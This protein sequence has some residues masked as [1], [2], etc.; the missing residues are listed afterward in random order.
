MKTNLW[1]LPAEN[2]P[3]SPTVQG[4]V[5]CAETCWTAILSSLLAVLMSLHSVPDEK[6]QW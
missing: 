3:P 4:A 1:L 5:L 2:E 6:G